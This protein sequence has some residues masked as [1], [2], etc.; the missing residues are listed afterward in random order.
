M[1]INQFNFRGGDF[2][3]IAPDM[4]VISLTA[5]QGFAGSPGLNDSDPDDISGTD[6]INDSDN[7]G[8]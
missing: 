3:Y 4:E 8:W 6:I 1:K 5:E 2:D 7:W